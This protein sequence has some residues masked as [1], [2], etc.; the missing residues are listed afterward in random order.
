MPQLGP[1][2]ACT[3]SCPVT[4]PLGNCA[5]GLTG[6]PGR[7]AACHLGHIPAST[8]RGRRI[9]GTAFI[10][11]AQGRLLAGRLAHSRRPSP[12]SGPEPSPPRLPAGRHDSGSSTGPSPGW[13][14]RAH[15]V[16]SSPSGWE[17]GGPEGPAGGGMAPR[18][19]LG[20]H[21]R[22]GDLVTRPLQQALRQESVFPRKGPGQSRSSL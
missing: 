22:D 9:A 7:D 2:L 17:V 13:D 8:R 10:R 12:A 20:G 11:V 21:L 4:L 3:H 15:P 6:P 5:G 16:D 18:T 14:L 19:L 1:G